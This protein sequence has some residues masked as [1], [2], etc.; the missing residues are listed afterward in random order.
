MPPILADQQPQLGDCCCPRRYQIQDRTKD[1][2]LSQLVL[3]HIRIRHKCRQRISSLVRV[4][5]SLKR[6]PSKITKIPELGSRRTVLN[7]AFS[8]PVHV[9]PRVSHPWSVCRAILKILAFAPV[10]RGIISVH[11]HLGQR[12]HEWH[13]LI[14]RFT[15]SHGP[16][17]QLANPIGLVTAARRCDIAIS[18]E[19]ALVRNIAPQH[20]VVSM[21][22]V[23]V[24]QIVRQHIA[25]RIPTK[26]ANCPL[27][28]ELDALL[29]VLEQLRPLILECCGVHVQSA[30]DVSR[31]HGK[32][33][34][35]R[36]HRSESPGEHGTL[37]CNSRNSEQ[38]YSDSC[39]NSAEINMRD[40]FS[41]LRV[42]TAGPIPPRSVLYVLG[43]SQLCR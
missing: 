20:D 1:G 35:S 37:G 38:W 8:G 6:I 9:A 36:R 14:R 39:N 32:R 15:R 27:C 29:R 33:Q 40:A 5:Q 23:M 41:D 24:S 11:Q 31:N 2:D 22:T 25:D 30:L 4:D 26:A 10:H 18:R 16:R 7:S 13:A 17:A 19:H 28:V 3:V 34:G 43:V 42:R 12:A 21:A